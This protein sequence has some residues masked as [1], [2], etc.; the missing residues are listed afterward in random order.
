MKNSI[1]VLSGG[2]D[3]ATTLLL[4]MIET[5]PKLALFFDYG[6]QH[7]DSELRCARYFASHADIPLRIIDLSGYGSAVTTNLTK[8]GGDVNTQHPNLSNLP[9]SF[10]PGRNLLFLTIASSIAR[11]WDATEIWT[12][13]NAVDYSG[14]PDCRETTIRA[15]EQAL[16]C[17]LEF[18]DLAIRTPL[19]DKTKADIWEIAYRLGML[20]AIIE[21]TH[22]GYTG[23]RSVRYVWG[24][25][26]ESAKYDPASMIRAEGFI[27]F[28]NRCHVIKTPIQVDTQT[29]IEES[30]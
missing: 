17:G 30:E 22:T 2:Q 10:V 11:D 7:R 25:G 1:I 5:R 18:Y 26:P 12:G 6:Q 9:S 14:Y 23:D 28:N 24:Y 27:E 16:R 29:T 3:S 19:I 8:P 4:A 20:D 15:L 21:H 13:V